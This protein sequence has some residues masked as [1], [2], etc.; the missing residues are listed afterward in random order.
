MYVH[1]YVNTENV[2]LSGTILNIVNFGAIYGKPQS[3]P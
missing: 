2:E 1:K 3:K